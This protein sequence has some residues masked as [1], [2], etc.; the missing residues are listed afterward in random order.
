VERRRLAIHRRHLQMLYPQAK[1]E[2]VRQYVSD[3]YG[4]R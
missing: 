2:E 4:R 3:V 1:P